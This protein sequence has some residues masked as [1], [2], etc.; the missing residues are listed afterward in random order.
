MCFVHSEGLV[1]GRELVQQVRLNP[2]A[3]S[4]FGEAPS[5]LQ[6]AAGGIRS[7][8]GGGPERVISGGGAEPPVVDGY[9]AVLHNRFNQDLAKVHPLTGPV[10]VEGAEPGDTLEV[11]ILDVS[12]LVDFGYVVITPVLGLFGGLGPSVL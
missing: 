3:A 1:P 8:G 4:A 2:A 9:G 6:S 11:E 10:E 7:E 12:P 5:G